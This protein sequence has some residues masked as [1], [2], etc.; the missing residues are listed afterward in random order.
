MSLPELYFRPNLLDSSGLR[1]ACYKSISF[2]GVAEG[3]VETT[4]L[5]L[6]KVDCEKRGRRPHVVGNNGL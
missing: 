2:Q 6:V 4:G 1:R 5:L 3:A